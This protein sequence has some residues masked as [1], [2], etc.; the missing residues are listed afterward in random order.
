MVIKVTPLLAYK[1]PVHVWES[2]HI[3]QK[4][5]LH[6]AVCGNGEEELQVIDSDSVFDSESSSEASE[7]MQELIYKLLYTFE[8]PFSFGFVYWTV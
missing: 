7:E 4:T 2:F 6:M 5:Q 1:N 3:H 8:D